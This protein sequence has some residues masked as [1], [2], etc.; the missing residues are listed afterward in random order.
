M[1]IQKTICPDAT[2]GF[3]SRLQ[4]YFSLRART[5][6]ILGFSTLFAVWVSA[7]TPPSDRPPVVSPLDR[8]QDQQSKLRLQEKIVWELEEQRRRALEESKKKS[9]DRKYE[10]SPGSQPMHNVPDSPVRSSD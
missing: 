7:D 1:R 5:L 9:E 4:H 6:A 10:V 3:I 8:E 2:S